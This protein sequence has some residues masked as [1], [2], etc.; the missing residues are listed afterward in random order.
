VLSTSKV[1]A[2]GLA[3]ATTAVLGS[4]FGVLGT[5]GAAAATSVVSAVSSEV[6]QRS[7]DRTANRLRARGGT[8]QSVGAQPEREQRTRRG[9]VLP[10]VIFGSLLIFA[11]GMAVVSGVEYVRGAPLSGGSG[12]TT[13][14][15]D[16]LHGT[17]SSTTQDVPVVGDLLGTNRTDDDSTSS[18]SGEHEK[19]G[20]K[21][22]LV[23]GILSGL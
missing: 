13:T 22:G 5:V 3:S 23:N 21:P 9:P 11:L 6:Y 16:V 1:A 15:G 2:A 17:V 19:H 4:Y 20:E 8:R 18:K 7:L 10:A 12:G 14:I